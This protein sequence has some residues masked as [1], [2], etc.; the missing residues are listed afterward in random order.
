MQKVRI[1]GVLLVLVFLSLACNFPMS[2]APTRPPTPVPMTTE[3]VQQ[4]EEQVAA[5]FE[6]PAP[7]GEVSITITDQQINAYLTDRLSSLSDPDFTIEEPQAHFTDGKVEVY[8]KVTRSSIKVDTKI[9]MTAQVS[10][11]G[12]TVLT[13]ESINLGPLPVPDTLVEK[14]NQNVNNLLDE[15]LSSVDASFTVKTIAITE[16]QMTI[17]GVREP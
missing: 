10:A 6:N 1:L 16:G 11:E 5:T 14:V 8:G 13:V 17:T 3:E 2:A 7:S 12:R 9:V 15:Y 4:F